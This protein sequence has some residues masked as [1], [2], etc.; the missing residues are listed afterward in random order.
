[1]Q[2]SVES[3]TGHPWPTGNGEGFLKHGSRWDCIEGDRNLQSKVYLRW[4]FW[5]R[6]WARALQSLSG[7]RAGAGPREADGGYSRST[8]LGQAPP[9]SHPLMPQVQMP[10]ITPRRLLGE[11]STTVPQGWSYVGGRDPA[12]D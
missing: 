1:M 6:L 5:E 3:N 11:M 7:Y 10:S 12:E 2:P 9:A 8:Q 4:L